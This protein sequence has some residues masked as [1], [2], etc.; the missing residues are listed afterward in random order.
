MQANGERKIHAQDN[1]GYDEY[2]IEEADG[3]V[4]SCDAG[5]SKGAE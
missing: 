1:E 5:C 3:E 2:K 4:L